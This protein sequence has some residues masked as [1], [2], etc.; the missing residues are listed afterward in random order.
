MIWEYIL[1]KYIR[2]QSFKMAL[3]TTEIQEV[4]LH[5]WRALFSHIQTSLLTPIKQ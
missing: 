4:L 2:G 3:I 5:T 1:G